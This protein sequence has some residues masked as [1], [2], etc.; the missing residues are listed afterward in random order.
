VSLAGCQPVP[1]LTQSWLWPGRSQPHVAPRAVGTSGLQPMLVASRQFRV[2]AVAAFRRWAAPELRHS[3]IASGNLAAWT[4]PIYG[5][6]LTA[7][8]VGAA[9]RGGVVE[10]LNRRAS[11]FTRCGA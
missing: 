5:V 6:G 9:R 8:A 4:V 1:N 3:G 7:T 2:G 10:D 11:W